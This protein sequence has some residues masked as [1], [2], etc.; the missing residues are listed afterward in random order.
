MLWTKTVEKGL[1]PVLVPYLV[2]PSIDQRFSF[3]M[4]QLEGAHPVRMLPFRS[5]RQ[6]LAMSRQEG[7]LLEP[8]NW[9]YSQKMPEMCLR[10]RMARAQE[11]VRHN[12]QQV[13]KRS[14]R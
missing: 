6:G 1:V 14:T 7:Q 5:S 8:S 3:R 13:Y 2:D 10:V 11:F 9:I 4:H 12:E